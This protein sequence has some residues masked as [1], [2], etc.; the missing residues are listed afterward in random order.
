MYGFARD[1]GGRLDLDL[2]RFAIGRPLS[3]LPSK[4]RIENREC[5]RSIAVGRK[6]P[7]LFHAFNAC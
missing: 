7:V 1:E 4:K 6:K 5:L 3:G 2:T